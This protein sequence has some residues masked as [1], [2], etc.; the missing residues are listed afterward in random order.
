MSTQVGGKRGDL[1]LLAR[2]NTFTL[3]HK[4]SP[5]RNVKY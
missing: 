3:T 5:G 4:R 2:H 1:T